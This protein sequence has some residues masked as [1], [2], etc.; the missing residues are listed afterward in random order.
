MPAGSAGPRIEYDEVGHA[1]H[2]REQPGSPGRV[3]RA[4][5]E[6]AQAEMFKGDALARR[7]R[8]TLERARVLLQRQWRPKARGAH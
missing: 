7:E 6:A 4:V 5:V 2:P 3:F 1:A 8:T